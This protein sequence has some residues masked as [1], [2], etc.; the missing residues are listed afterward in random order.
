[1]QNPSDLALWAGSRAYEKIQRDGLTPDCV[2][3]IVGSAGGPKVLTLVNLDTVL[4]GDWLADRRRPLWLFGSSIS[5]WRFACA[6]QPNPRIAFDR[7]GDL[8]IRSGL[9]PNATTLQ[10]TEATQAMLAELL[11]NADMQRQLIEHP[12]YR[13]AITI[14]KCKGLSASRNRWVLAGALGAAFVGNYVSSSLLRFFFNRV[15]LHD[16]RELPP[17]SRVT[18]SDAVFSPLTLETIRDALAA[19]T[20]IPFFI[21]PVEV[22]RDWPPGLYRDGG[23]MDYNFCALKLEHHGITLFPHFTSTLNAS[24]FDKGLS[25]LHKKFRKMFLENFLIV[26]PTSQFIQRLPYKKIPDRRDYRNLS[27]FE[28]IVYWK[29]VV[30][31]GQRL[32]DQF[33]ELVLKENLVQSVRRLPS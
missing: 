2:S 15:I 11:G 17:V 24:W 22:V 30:A 20:A 19:T 28:R 9:P 13:L 23:L 33:A 8:Y 32:G 31:E 16:P 25:P 7:F 3:S 1:M 18:S 26:C 6:V 21:D 27:N 12:Y 10:V 5:A 29:K 4:F 14:S